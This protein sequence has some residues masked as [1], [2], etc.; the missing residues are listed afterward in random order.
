MKER[1]FKNSTW[2]WRAS[3]SALR[4]N[5]GCTPDPTE[6]TTPVV[7]TGHRYLIPSESSSNLMSSLVL[8][9]SKATSGYS[10]ILLLTLFN[11][12]KNSDSLAEFNISRV[13]EVGAAIAAHIAAWHEKT[14]DMVM[15]RKRCNIWSAFVSFGNLWISL[16]TPNRGK[17]NYIFIKAISMQQNWFNLINSIKLGYVL[18]LCNYKRMTH[19]SIIL[20]QY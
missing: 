1:K 5:H 15:Q 12:S 19:G 3:I 6:A 2:T 18:D 16:I 17:D 13:G 10:C 11:H 4:P 9:S 14:V 8:N 20:I 7:A